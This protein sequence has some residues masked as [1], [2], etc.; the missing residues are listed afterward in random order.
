M[1]DVF[2]KSLPVERKSTGHYA[3]GYWQEDEVSTSTIQ[4]SIQATEV[5]VLQILPEGYRTRTSYTLFT[6]SSLLTAE[7]GVR[8]PDIVVIDNERFIVVSSMP[9]QNLAST[10]HYEVV[11]VKENIDT[12]R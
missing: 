1:F 8:T 11:V 3:G 7:A 12:D 4:A 5:E 9:W 2:R 6:D 10:Q